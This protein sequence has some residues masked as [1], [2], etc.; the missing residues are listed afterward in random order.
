MINKLWPKCGA[1][2]SNNQQILKRTVGSLEGSVADGFGEGFDGSEGGGDLLADFVGGGKGFVSQPIMTDHSVFVGVGDGAGFEVCHGLKG[3]LDGF[4]VL[5]EVFVGEVDAAEVEA[6]PNCVMKGGLR[7]VAFP[8]LERVG[9]HGARGAYAGVED[10]STLT[11]RRA[12]DREASVLLRDQ[13]LLLAL[14][15]L[16]CSG[17]VGS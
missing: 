6:E 1:T 8:K 9:L 10:V 17:A 14:P 16:T 11:A 4:G 13:N 2:D 3:G 7:F 12:C 5:V 15:L